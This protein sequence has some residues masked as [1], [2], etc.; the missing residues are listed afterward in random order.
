MQLKGPIK[1][2]DGIVLDRGEKMVGRVMRTEIERGSEQ[3]KG[4][5]GNLRKRQRRKEDKMET[6]TY[7]HRHHQHHF[8]DNFTPTLPSLSPHLTLLVL[9]SRF[10]RPSIL[11]RQPRGAGGGRSGVRGVGQQGQT[12]S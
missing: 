9:H 7:F 4:G 1:R 6:F 5:E 3:K 2:G 8:V 12:H 10:Q 11:F